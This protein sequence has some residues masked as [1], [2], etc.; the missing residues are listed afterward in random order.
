MN[1]KIIEKYLLQN[2]KYADVK[3]VKKL[4][5]LDYFLYNI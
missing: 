5:D 2:N 4:L 1:I 3:Y